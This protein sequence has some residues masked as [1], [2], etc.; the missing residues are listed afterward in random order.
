WQQAAAQGIT[1]FVSSGDSGAAGCDPGGASAGTGPGVNGLA[2]TPNNVAVGGTQFNEGTG[3]YWSATNGTGYHYGLGYVP[4]VSWNESGTVPGGS[5]L[6]S[7]GGGASIRYG[8]PAWQA[9]PG[10]PLD[11]RRDVPDVSLTAAG[12]DAYLVVSQA[13]GLYS[14]NGTSAA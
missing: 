1:S 6:W 5:G 3:S 8:K 4:E 12:H 13:G 10:V 2:S 7:T 11:G 9:A 14:I